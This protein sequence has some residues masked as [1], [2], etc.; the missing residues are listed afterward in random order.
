M[1]YLLV[2]NAEKYDRVFPKVKL[3]AT[4]CIVGNTTCMKHCWQWRAALI[5]QPQVRPLRAFLVGI[6]RYVKAGKK[7]WGEKGRK[8]GKKE[9]G[10]KERRKGEWGRKKGVKLSHFYAVV[11]FII[12]QLSFLIFFS[13]S[14]KGEFLF[15]SLDLCKY[16]R[17]QTG[18]FERQCQA[19]SKYFNNPEWN[20]SQCFFPQP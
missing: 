19:L 17:N 4:S 8:E 20:F 13:G 18:E 16:V 2:R 14:D 7:E 9:Q 1:V 5:R 3:C 11:L 6:L 10:I 15:F 12:H